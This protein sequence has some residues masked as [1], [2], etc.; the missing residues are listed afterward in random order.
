MNARASPEP[1]LS[2]R[3]CDEER[4]YQGG[5]ENFAEAALADYEN[6]RSV[7][8]REVLGSMFCGKKYASVGSQ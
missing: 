4:G 2:M 7:L 5:G 6:W 3:A 8:S 1:E